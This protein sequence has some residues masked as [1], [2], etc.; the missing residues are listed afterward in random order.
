M[1]RTGENIYRR[2]DGRWE[3]RYIRER[4][5]GKARYGSVYAR[6]YR[7]VKRKLEEARRE[8]KKK[9]SPEPGAKSLADI[10]QRWLSEA[11]ATLKISSVNKY[12]DLFRCYIMPEFG[13]SDLSEI[14]NQRLISFANGLLVSG[15][16][17]KQGLTLATVTEILSAMNSIRI[18]A[19]KHNYVVG[20]S[21]ECVSL[22]KEQKDIRVFSLEEEEKLL[23]Y[24]Q[25]HM[26]LS[27]L[28]ILLCLY[29]GIRI[30]ELCAMKWDDISLMERKMSVSKTMQR[31]RVSKE[32]VG[33]TEVKILEPKSSCSVRIIPL[34]D[35]LMGLL[36][37]FYVPGAFLL[38]G[39][40]SQFI[41]PR[42]MENRFR[43]ILA[44]C[45]IQKA[46]FHTTRHTFA[47]RCI[48]AGFDVKSLSEILGH[49]SVAIT[50]NRYV[51]P[52]MA[53]KRENMNRFS[54]LFTVR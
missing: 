40:H 16:A 54:E 8:P 26:S 47:T 43:K 46:N 15:G 9:E 51:H 13:E 44:S 38:T 2:K 28:G 33:K 25:E 49:A 18:Y 24:L 29:T 19:M 41:E 34:P 21:T 22:K 12:E 31:I 30:G 32:G 39:A 7:E 53:L 17:K 42:T 45:G 1:P 27:E 36:E 5:G 11:T 6:S 20:F 37:K 14:T 3:G 50:M 10:G 35:T 23:D 4:S 48:E 52:S